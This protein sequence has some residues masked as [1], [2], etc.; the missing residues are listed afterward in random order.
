MTDMKKGYD[1]LIINNL[2]KKPVAPHFNLTGLNTN[3]IN[4]ALTIIN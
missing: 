4:H 1:N 3:Q 2:Y